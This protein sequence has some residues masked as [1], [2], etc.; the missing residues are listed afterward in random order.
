[1]GLKDVKNEILQDAE[2][3]AESIREEGRKEDEA[4]KISEAVDEEIESQKSSL[5]KK[6]VSNANM[7]AKK[8]KLEAKQD[9]IQD[10]FEEFSEEIREMSESDR[11]KFVES[12]LASTE[13]EVGKVLGSSEF[14]SVVDTEFEE[15]EEEG[16]IVIS[17]SGDRRRNFTFDKILEDFREDYRKK[18]AEKLFE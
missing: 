8:K 11:E 1:M 7:E 5:E 13:F 9:S 10:T 6:A 2:D 4:E 16:I 18:V 14:K 17:E 12:V 3:E 15:I